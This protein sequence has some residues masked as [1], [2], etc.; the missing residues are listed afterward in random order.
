MDWKKAGIT[1]TNEQVALYRQIA[2]DVLDNFCEDR[3]LYA[4][5]EGDVVIDSPYCMVEAGATKVVLIPDGDWVLKIPFY[6]CKSN[7]KVCMFCEECAKYSEYC[8]KRDTWYA[9]DKKRRDAG[10]KI[11]DWEGFPESPCDGCEKV[12]YETYYNEFA[13]AN[14][15]A[16]C[17]EEDE[18]VSSWD[19]CEEEV[20]LYN[21]A[22]EWGIE[23]AFAQTMLFDV[24][25]SNPVYLQKKIACRDDRK[26][27]SKESKEAYKKSFGTNGYELGE[28]LGSV[29]LEKCGYDFT[30]ELIRFIE[31]Y[32]ISDLHYGNWGF[33]GDAPKI[34]DYAG[35]HEND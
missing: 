24:I 28:A 20:Y 25:D 14:H 3:A 1:L 15:S 7:G 19:Y 10:E 27:S 6:G 32:E 33:D 29:M 23:D 8:N 5:E 26:I 4:E 31:T 11:R 35:Y 9:E 17:V 18:A 21:K 34:F 22:V 16:G 12:E 13:C 30:S 2:E